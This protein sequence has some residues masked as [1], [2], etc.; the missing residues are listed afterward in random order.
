MELK[1]LANLKQL[2]SAKKTA[3]AVLACGVTFGIIAGAY[4]IVMK[5]VK[6]I[7]RSG[8]YE[9]RTA[10][11]T[12][13]GALDQIGIVLLPEDLVEPEVDAVLKYFAGIIDRGY[14]IFFL[15]ISK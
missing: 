2:V 11:K 3:A 6:V 10:A 9:V 15:W 8:T 4:N 7:D 13:K 5:D 1:P 12:V 14:A